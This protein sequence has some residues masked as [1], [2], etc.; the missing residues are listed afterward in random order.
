MSEALGSARSLRNSLPLRKMDRR[1]RT[2]PVE[3]PA[4]GENRR[5]KSV[6]LLKLWK[7]CETAFTREKGEKKESGARGTTNH[8]KDWRG[9]SEWNLWNSLSLE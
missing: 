6:E 2:G 7:A 3:L 8:W 1:R 4:T 9:R 5:R